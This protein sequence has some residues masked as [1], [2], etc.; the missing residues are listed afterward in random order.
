M[1]GLTFNDFFIS[2]LSQTCR[3]IVAETEGQSDRLVYS[4]GVNMRPPPT[5]IDDVVIENT[6]GSTKITLPTT[7]SIKETPAVKRA[8]KGGFEPL[9]MLSCLHLQRKLL[10]LLPIAA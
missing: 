6:I 10:P 1:P 8:L 4:V 5:S 2:C 9:N 3:Q 7:D